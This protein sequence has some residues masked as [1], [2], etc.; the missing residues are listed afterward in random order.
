[1]TENEAIAHE[2]VGKLSA[3]G[4]DA[5]AL[6]RGA[7]WRVE[8]ARVGARTLEVHCFWYG[9]SVSGLLLGMN[10]ANARSGLGSAQVPYQG[11]EFLVELYEYEAHIADGRTHD[12][13]DVVACVGRVGE[14]RL[15]LET[16]CRSS[17]QKMR[18]CGGPSETRA[19]IDEN[20]SRL[21]VHKAGVASPCESSERISLASSRCASSTADQFPNTKPT[22]KLA[23]VSVK[24]T[25]PLPTSRSWLILCCCQPISANM[26]NLREK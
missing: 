9:R 3:A 23:P 19:D 2:L 5:C 10:S 21:Y 7:N 25:S 14:P 15:N 24:S 18:E 13:A 26:P 16:D 12:A 8:V 22:L 17:R 1:M 11:P 20:V 6:G 4:F